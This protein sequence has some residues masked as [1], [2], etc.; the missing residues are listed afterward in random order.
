M[1]IYVEP[2]E[3][4]PGQVMSATNWNDWIV[5][6]DRAMWAYTGKGQL[7]VASSSNQLRALAPGAKLSVLQVN[8]SGDDV[9]WASGGIYVHAQKTTS[10]SIGS[11]TLTKIALDSLSGSDP[12]GL[13]VAASNRI[14]IPTGMDGMYDFY[15][16]GYWDSHGTAGTLRQVAIAHSISGGPLN[17]RAAQTTPV[18]PN[19]VMWMQA[20]YHAYCVAGD[21]IEFQAQ[22]N[23]GSALSFNN[24]H[25][26]VERR[27]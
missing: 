2:P 23:S 4:V 14:V 1:T 19:E 21:I 10:Q 27:R 6:V 9:E 15:V 17:V 22:Q 18:S 8:A 5:Q 16:Q 24:I 13:F 7:A 26:V 12:Y 3:V 11:N 25:M 20:V